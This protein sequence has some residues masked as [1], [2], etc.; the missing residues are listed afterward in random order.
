MERRHI[1]QSQRRRPPNEIRGAGFGFAGIRVSLNGFSV[2]LA[3]RRMCG[4]RASTVAIT[5]QFP[6]A[7]RAYCNGASKLEASVSTVAAALA[8]L[9]QAHPTLHRCFCDETGAVRRHINIWVNA[10]H[11]SQCE[12]LETALAPGDVLSILPAVSGG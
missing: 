7:L 11:L 1:R 9:R 10:T 12:G 4:D 5:I 2:Y 8:H 3:R 6:G